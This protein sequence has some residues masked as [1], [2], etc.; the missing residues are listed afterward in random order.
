MTAFFCA[1]PLP[2]LPPLKC[3]FVNKYP[4]ND[5][6]LSMPPVSW[7]DPDWPPPSFPLP[8]PHPPTIHFSVLT[9]VV[10]M[11]FER[12]GTTLWKVDPETKKILT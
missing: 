9:S 4:L 12:Q 8:S 6:Y 1:A 2:L 7:G 11:E 3:H 5:P 10:T